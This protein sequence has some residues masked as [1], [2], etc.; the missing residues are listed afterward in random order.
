MG[1]LILRAQ[2]LITLT[3]IQLIFRAYDKFAQR[4]Y[5]LIIYGIPTLQ[6]IVHL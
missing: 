3:I 1:L 6:L 5:S 2:V 4:Y